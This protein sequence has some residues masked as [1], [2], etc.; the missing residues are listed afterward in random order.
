MFSQA[1][2]VM[3]KDK[4]VL[5]LRRLVLEQGESIAIAAR[6]SGMCETTA[7]KYIRLGKLP[8]ETVKPR[9]WRTRKDPFEDVWEEAK[10]FLE[11]NPNLEVTALFGELQRRYPGKFQ[12][13]QLRTLQRHVK[14]WKATEGPPKEV[15]F[16]QE[17]KPG[18]RAQSDFT[19][20]NKLGVTIGGVPFKHKLFHFVLT[21][22]NWQTGS[23]CRSESFEAL[24]E[25]LQHALQACGGVPR[26]H[27]TDSLSAAVRRLRRRDGEAFTDR[28]Q[29]LMRHCGMEARHTQARSPHENGKVE[30]AHY[31]LKQAIANQLTLRGS[32]DFESQQ[33]YE[34]FL[35]KLFVQLNTPRKE[36]FEEERAHMGPLPKRPLTTYKPISVRVSKGSTI[37]VQNN[38]Y[39]VPSRLIGERVD[40][41]LYGEEVQVWYRNRFMERM[42]RLHGR[43][44]HRI[45]Y[46]HV[47]SSLV[48]K[49]GAFADYRYRSDFFPTH[50]FQMA[51]EALLREHGKGTRAD[52]E[53]LQVLN[54]AARG[55]ESGVDVVLDE[56]LGRKEAITAEGVE[57]M[58]GQ[59]VP[60]PVDGIAPVEVNLELYDKLLPQSKQ[61]M[62]AAEI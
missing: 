17:Y 32:S 25:G 27:Q 1:T 4:Q 26:L 38:F 60:E 30:Q 37:R 58:L 22:S 2:E 54:L 18:D 8:S 6:K 43:S 41:R 39:S 33:K 47:I 57:A 36:R 16:A 10:E 46:R 31:R 11:M 21:Y 15:Y 23:V 34:A 51:Y 61:G 52:K 35:A 19:C 56:L 62:L 29:A 9:T 7:R 42:P 12:P 24:S 50:R 53:Y 49:P 44:K 48:R 55:G 14:Y 45:G 13:G 20:M 3:V 5:H 59:N 28:Y 40:V